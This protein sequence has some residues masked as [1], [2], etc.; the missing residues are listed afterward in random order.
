MKIKVTRVSGKWHARL[1]HDDK[2]LDEMSCDLRIDIGFICR[3]M[4]RW[5]DKMGNSNEQTRH[6]RRSQN[7]NPIGRVY[8]HQQT[9]D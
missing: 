6:A 5:Q 9:G 1:I 8:Y 3:E 4:M 7:S 2:I